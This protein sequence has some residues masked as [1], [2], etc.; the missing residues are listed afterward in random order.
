LKYYY[1]Y[2]S[3][4]ISNI[5]EALEQKLYYPAFMSALCLPDICGYISDPENL[6]VRNR[7]IA[8]FEKYMSDSYQDYMSGEEAYALR[9][10][11]LHNGELS[12]KQYSIRSKKILLDK[13]EVFENGIHLLRLENNK[14]DGL[15]LPNIVRLNS[16]NYCKDIISAV[17]AW[18]KDTGK[19]ISDNE[20]VFVISEGGDTFVM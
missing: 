9:C 14:V 11:V 19:S 13:F 3:K 18:Q 16:T 20:E 2:I 17:K 15:V 10:V 6:S 4:L 5:E 1:E 12:T 8:W 7:Y